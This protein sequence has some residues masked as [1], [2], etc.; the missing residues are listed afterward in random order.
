[1]SVRR[2]GTGW[3]CD[4]RDDF[5]IRRRK[6]FDL[7]ADADLYE[8]ERRV[9]AHKA[10]DSRNGDAPACDPNIGFEDYGQRFL[11]Q[12][13]AQGVDPATISR[14]ET[15]LRV[16][17]FPTFGKMKVRAIARGAV[18]RLLLDLLGGDR[19]ARGSVR[20]VYATLCAVLT[21]AIEDGLLQSHPAR[22]LWRK[23]GKGQKDEHSKIKAFTSEQARAFVNAARQHESDRF[24]LF[25]VCLLG[26]LRIG[27]ALGLKTGDIDLAKKRL[28]VSRQIGQIGGAK[29]TKSGRSRDVELSETLASILLEATVARATAAEA[30]ADAETAPEDSPWLLVSELPAEPSAKDVARVYKNIAR[31][32]TRAV[33]RA[34]INAEGFTLHALRHSYAS[35]LISRGISPAFVQSQLGHASI[36]LTVRTYGSWLPIT[37]PGAVDALAEALVGPRGHH[38]DTLERKDTAKV[39]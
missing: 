27:E 6:T 35:G 7:K 38:L 10:K 19:L 20:Q 1:V 16:H 2:H 13:K 32:F 24:P 8:K 15:T 34:G 11:A 29:S 3:R 14:Q 33:E 5:G 25:A 28:R 30:E 36:D 18:R 22:G 9:E 26:G 21:E 39:A 4:W 12:R 31:A 37:V 23:L 17:L